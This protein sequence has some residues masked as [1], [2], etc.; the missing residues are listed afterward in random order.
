MAL[1]LTGDD[2]EAV[3]TGNLVLEI[4]YDDEIVATVAAK[5]SSATWFFEIPDL[6]F[7]GRGFYRVKYNDQYLN[8]WTPF[9]RE[10]G[11]E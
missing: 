11:C 3:A 4:K 1:A 10:G 2:G 7:N 5:Y 9:Y 6:G 8:F